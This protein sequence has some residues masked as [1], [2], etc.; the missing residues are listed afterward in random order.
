MKIFV[1]DI[2]DLNLEVTTIGYTEKGESQVVV[3]FDKNKKQTLLSFVIDCYSNGNSNITID[4]L[5]QYG[6]KHL[7]YF[8]WTHTD[9]DH[10][11]GIG[12]IIDNFCTNQTNFFLPEGVTGNEKDFINYNN[13]IKETFE[14]INS[15]NAAGNYNVHSLTSVI[16]GHMQVLKKYFVDSRT[17]KEII[18]EV[19]AVAP[20]SALIRRRWDAGEVKKKNDLSIATIFK[21]GELALLFS[22]DIE[23]QTI[24][25]IPDFYFEGLSYIK[26]PHHTSKSST[27]LINKIENVFSDIKIPSAVTTTYRL[28]NLPNTDL[29]SEYKKYVEVFSSTGEGENGYGCVKTI[30]EI[31]KKEMYEELIGDAILH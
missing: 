10:S 8:I 18:F 11:I 25:Q 20:L 4:V 12:D 27:R 30:F 17:S 15:F 21:V 6:I 9:D 26:T 5:K 19:L 3:L 14:K 7:D 13:E 31:V 28:H 1:D 2:N 29:I 16:G 23:N 24:N 22:G